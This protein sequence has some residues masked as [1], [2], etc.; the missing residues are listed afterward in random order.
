M[1]GRTP[2]NTQFTKRGYL[3]KTKTTNIVA[4]EI[5]VHGKIKQL[6]YRRFVYKQAKEQKIMGMVK[7][8]EDGVQTEG[9]MIIAEGETS[10][11]ELFLKKCRGDYPFVEINSFEYKEIVSQ[12]F[13]EFKI[14]PIRQKSKWNLVL[15]NFLKR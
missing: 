8:L 14:Y 5:I 4:I 10:S 6:G 11:I 7:Y 3:M 15:S 1:L 2:D 13:K 9:L 12:N